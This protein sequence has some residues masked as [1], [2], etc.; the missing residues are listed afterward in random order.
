MAETVWLHVD[1]T[2]EVFQ[3]CIITFG[4][5]NLSE[6]RHTP[7]KTPLTVSSWHDPLQ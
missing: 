3:G 1:I 4:S 2:G 7:T 5:L 6:Q